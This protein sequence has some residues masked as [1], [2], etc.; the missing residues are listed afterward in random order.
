MKS[1]RSILAAVG[2]GLVSALALC[3]VVSPTTA[4]YTDQ[5]RAESESIAASVQPAARAIR[6]ANALDT[7]AA[8]VEGQLYLW[9]FLGLGANP[10]GGLL[11]ALT[12]STEY[13]NQPPRLFRPLTQIIDVSA[14]AYG[15]KAV[16]VDGQLWTWGTNGYYENGGLSGQVTASWVS[17][18]TQVVSVASSEYANAWLKEDGT[19]WTTGNGVYGQRGNG[20][21]T[22]TSTPTRAAFPASAS[23]IIYLGGAYE[24]FYAVDSNLTVYYWGRNF[25]GGAGLPSGAASQFTAPTEVPAL[26]E[27]VRGEGLEYLG[28]GYAWGALHTEAGNVYTWGTT[29]TN[30]NGHVP[31][32]VGTG[33]ALYGPRL[34]AAGVKMLSAS[35]ATGRVI[36]EDGTVW[37]WGSYQWGGA[38]KLNGANNTTNALAIVYD[39][40]S[41]PAGTVGGTKDNGAYTLEADGSL[42]TWGEN[43]AGAACRGLAGASCPNNQGMAGGAGQLYVW[44]PY[45]TE[46]P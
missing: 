37:A 7:N 10:G 43:G 3:A 34:L 27:L 36:L 33:G 40:S 31:G 8:L 15:Y 24:G 42:W 46:V 14:N 17:L 41:G 35:Y 45:K 22:T 25:R 23:E 38:V 13:T 12:S 29:E 39:G 6:Q 2:A 28:G 1:A 5:A 20:S 26:T 4:G 19:V 21:T 16:T 11:G 32:Y 30:S 9:G 18:D 44:P